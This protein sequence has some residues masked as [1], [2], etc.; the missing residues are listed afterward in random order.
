MSA[1]E[2]WRD[3]ATTTLAQGERRL[4]V[5]MVTGCAQRAFFAGVNQATVR[6]LSAEGCEV[7]A[8]ASKAAA[9]RWPHAGER[10]TPRRVFAR[11]LIAVFERANVDL[12][13]INAAGCGS[14]MKNA[15]ICSRT[16]R[17]WAARLDT[18]ARQV[19]DVS[20]ILAQLGPPEAR[21]IRCRRVWRITMPVTSLTRRGVRTQ[22]RAVL[23]GFPASRSRPLLK[24][25]AEA[26]A[27][28]I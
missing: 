28:S 16:T 26:R 21:A 1:G 18:F 12:I 2:L 6:V 15:A 8:P 9:V 14:A 20:E 4:R 10:A 27:S 25:S 19:R 23:A 11:D 3:T 7:N 22:P 5:G 24:T 13:A 17:P